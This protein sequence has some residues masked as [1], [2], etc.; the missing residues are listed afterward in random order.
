MTVSLEQA[1][2][3]ESSSWPPSKYAYVFAEERTKDWT[4]R[5]EEYWK[6]EAEK[7]MEEAQTGSYEET[8]ME[9]ARV[10][11]RNTQSEFHGF[12]Y[13]PPE[14]RDM[15]YEYRLMKGSVFM[16]NIVGRFHVRY[17]IAHIRDY[18]GE[19]YPRYEGL[20]HD[21]E[22]LRE[23][24]IGLICGVSHTIQAEAMSIFYGRNRFVFP[25]G[26][27]G[28]P[29]FYERMNLPPYRHVSNHIRDISHTFDMREEVCSNYNRRY[30]TRFRPD[31]EEGIDAG[32]T[33][34]SYMNQLHDDAKSDV[35][36]A[37]GERVQDIKCMKLKRLQI[38]LEECYCGTGCCRLVDAVL[39]YLVDTE[40][41]G[42]WD[43]G[44]PKVIEVY[45]WND[46][47]EKNEIRESLDK[48]SSEEASVEI[49]F[50]GKSK[51][52]VRAERKAVAG[53]GPQAVH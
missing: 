9:R 27:I 14:L 36:F 31:E 28:F 24:K 3:W 17:D 37:W 12:M 21:W 19:L 43:F 13:L 5:L 29:M 30:E 33:P 23:K 53:Q 39:D 41:I 2:K 51:A 26:H 20:P 48:L 44:P 49:R 1:M 6:R 16:P 25:Y 32:L 7:R 35:L 4:T 42:P 46:E 34:M 47:A 8:E 52:E 38:S 18:Y 10:A 11:R 50:I 15:V 22:T 45:G 40:E